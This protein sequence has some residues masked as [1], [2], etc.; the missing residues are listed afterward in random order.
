LKY[1]LVA[2]RKLFNERE[3]LSKQFKKE[4][5]T[6]QASYEEKYKPIYDERGLIIEGKKEVT[7]EEITAEAS[8]V[9]ITGVVA[10]SQEKGIPNFWGTAIANCFQFKGIVNPKDKLILTFLRDIRVIYLQ[11][12]SF[13]LIFSFDKNEYLDHETLKRT[14]KVNPSTG[15]VNKIESTVIQWKSD[16]QNPTIEK[17][18]KK[19]K[20]KKKG[21]VK[22]V[23][24]VEEIASFFNT[25]KSYEYDENKEKEKKK[26]EADEDEEEEE[27]DEQQIIDDEYDLGLFIKDDFIPFAMEYYLDINPEGDEDFEDEEIESEEEDPKGKK[28]GYQKL[29]K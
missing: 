12:N 29:K 27:E 8:K 6:L 24:K 14:F 1:K 2:L 19:I 4:Q 26:E 20:S 15:Y 16:D 22:T 9:G 10:E 21:E 3:E 11:D 25:F 18:K 13:E 5:H 23:T 17:K 28:G 7:L